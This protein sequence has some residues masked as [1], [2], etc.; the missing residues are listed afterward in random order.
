[1]K[2][3]FL[4][5]DGVMDSES[6]N[7]MLKKQGKPLKD[8]YGTIFDPLCVK[9]LKYITDQTGASI[10]VTSLWKRIMSYGD[11]VELWGYRELPGFVTGVTPNLGKRFNRGDE[12]DAWLEECRTDVQYVIIDDLRAKYFKDHQLSRLL[13]VDPIVGLDEDTAERA[14]ELFNSDIK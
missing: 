14:I 10:V 5:F 4:D 8:K 13:N 1:M 6:Y 7:H 3:L 9:N 11:I 2:I 12:I